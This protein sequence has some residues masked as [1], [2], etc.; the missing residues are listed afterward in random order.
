M[1]HG[2]IAM[3]SPTQHGTPDPSHLSMDDRIDLLCDRFEEAWQ[4]DKRPVLEA[5]VQENEGVDTTALFKE[6][7]LLDLEYRRQAGESPEREDYEKRFS[8]FT[9]LIL[10]AVPA[11][12]TDKLS[13]TAAREPGSLQVVKVGQRIAQ[14]E[15]VERLGAG[16][17]GA[18]WKARDTTLKRAVALKLPLAGDL[19][20]EELRR[21]IREGQAAAQ[22]NHPNI[23]SVH[24]VDAS[25]RPLTLF[26]TTSAG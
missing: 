18:V 8:Q 24:E 10:K 6:L 16:A 21:F 26:Q 3:T 23:V 20:A 5:F 11:G 2:N 9:D 7:L 17:F 4:S 15:I 14:F 25:T 22:L 1:G 13:K 12:K 19:T